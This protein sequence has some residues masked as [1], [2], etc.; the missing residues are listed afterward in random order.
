[1]A[2]TTTAACL[3]ALPSPL[4]E[5]IALHLPLRDRWAG[6]DCQRRLR[7]QLGGCSQLLAAWGVV[8]EEV[9]WLTSL[10]IATQPLP[11]AGCTS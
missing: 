1:M 9:E 7:P 2:S 4:L 3:T 11:H 8:G 6:S 10:P 5:L